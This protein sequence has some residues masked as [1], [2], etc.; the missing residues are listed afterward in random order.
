MRKNIAFILI[1]IVINVAC[2]CSAHKSGEIDF[3]STDEQVYEIETKYCQIC[4]PQKWENEVDIVISEE[5]P[6]TVHFSTA[7]GEKEVKL[8]DIIFDE[9][10]GFKIGMLQSDKEIHDLY[11]VNYDF[12]REN[13]SE[14]DYFKLCEMCDDVNVIISKL[15]ES[16][17]FELAN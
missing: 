1:F 8:F 14:E 4:Y 3:Y 11:I 9:E 16:N 2:G 7:I 17:N 15:L 5:S 6:Y 12:K 13:F 10:D